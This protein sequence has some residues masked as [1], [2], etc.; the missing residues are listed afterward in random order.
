MAATRTASEKSF[1][2]S[3][4]VELRS[5]H[6]H[7]KRSASSHYGREVM[8]GSQNASREVVTQRSLSSA[9]AAAAQ[10]RRQWSSSSRLNVS[11]SGRQSRNKGSS[12]K[13]VP[14]PV[15]FAIGA[16]R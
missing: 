3:D 12:A 8:D 14:W 10:F 1:G 13:N 6:D 4:G 7:P 2:A 15:K 11:S 5:A 16:P 9:N